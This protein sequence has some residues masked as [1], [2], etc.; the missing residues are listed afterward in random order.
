MR[1]GAPAPAAAQLEA[2]VDDLHAPAYRVVGA[3]DARV[4]IGTVNILQRLLVHD[5]QLVCVDADDAR[6]PRRAHVALSDG[7][8]GFEHFLR[9]RLQPPPLRG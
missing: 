2:A 7:E 6:D 1:T 8:Q 5:A 4:G 3:R 9:M